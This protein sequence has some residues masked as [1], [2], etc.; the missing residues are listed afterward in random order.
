[1]RQLFLLGDSFF[2]SNQ[3]PAHS[4]LIAE[5]QETKSTRTSRKTSTEKNIYSV[6]E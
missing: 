1:M 4:C 5:Q 2:P 3:Q 6:L